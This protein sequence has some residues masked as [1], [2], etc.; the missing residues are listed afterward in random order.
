MKKTVLTLV[1]TTLTFF[2]APTKEH[3][4]EAFKFMDELNFK[5]LMS[6]SVENSV[7]TL[8]HTNPKLEKHKEKL[9]GFY[10]KCVSYDAIK[11]DLAEMYANDFT[12]E[13]L[14]EMTA[15]YH[16]KLGKKMLE[17]TPSLMQ[18]SMQ[19]GQERVSKN[20]DELNKILE[21]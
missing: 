7:K 15:F 12:A 1:C 4:E 3:K 11:D 9:K 2:G 17:K 14:K 21:N 18:K 13:E 20:M 6:D 16:S 19:F 10:E 5:K 8:I